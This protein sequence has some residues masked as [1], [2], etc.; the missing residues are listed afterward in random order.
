M[1]FYAVSN[2]LKAH[3]HIALASHFISFLSTER[4]RRRPTIATCK[5]STIVLCA[6]ALRGCHAPSSQQLC[7]RNYEQK[8]DRNYPAGSAWEPNG[9]Y[10]EWHCMLN[11]KSLRYQLCQIR[12]TILPTSGSWYTYNC[13]RKVYERCAHLR[14][15]KPNTISYRPYGMSRWKIRR[16]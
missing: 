4:R 16:M 14:E 5:P 7:A 10:P 9:K 13:Q 6:P 3:K 1:E 8:Y 15:K 12:S 2:V 11:N